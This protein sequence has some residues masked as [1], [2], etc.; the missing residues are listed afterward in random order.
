MTVNDITRMLNL[1]VLA[2]SQG[3]EKEIQAGYTSDLL[4]DV[5]GN[6][7]PGTVWITLQTHKN[8][9][10]VASLKDHAAVII[11][12]NH[13][14]NADA[15]AQAEEEGIPLL[16]T[17]MGAFEVSGKLYELLAKTS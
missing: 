9:I 8:V 13:T 14:P 10:A 3:L 12:N 7:Q 16:S 1:K 6:S 17:R 2:G 11:I 15:V 4:S 5:M